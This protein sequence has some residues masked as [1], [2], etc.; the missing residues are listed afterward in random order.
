MK[1]IECEVIR[2]VR[3]KYEDKVFLT[4]QGKYK[5]GG[6][7]GRSSFDY[8]DTRRCLSIN[9]NIYWYTTE[10][11][12]KRKRERLETV[13]EEWKSG[14]FNRWDSGKFKVPLWFVSSFRL[15]IHED[16]LNNIS[17]RFKEF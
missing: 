14:K 10:K 6:I 16:M 1:K 3:E 17:L 5:F 4:K 11:L 7:E 13:M 15:P 12:P 8:F 9:F 2:A